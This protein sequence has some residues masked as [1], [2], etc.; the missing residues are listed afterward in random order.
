MGRLEET[1]EAILDSAA[2]VLA[3]NPRASLSDIATAASIGRATLHRHFS[4]RN[5]L[6]ITLARA[7]IQAIDAAC[8]HIDYHGQSAADSLR[9]TIEAIVPLGARYSF[10][11]YQGEV[12]EDEQVRAELTRQVESVRALVEA[13]KLEGGV[14]LDVPTAWVVATIDA[15]IYAGWLEVHR[16]SIAARDVAGLVLRTITAG[17]GPRHPRSVRPDRVPAPTRC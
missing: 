5:D 10:L 11:A 16:K 4:S 7:S 14:G 13:L 17:L 9:E 8:A 12:L 2:A 15:L 3:A 6:V 1:R